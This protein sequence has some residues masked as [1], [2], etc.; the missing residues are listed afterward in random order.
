MIC[1]FSS[2]IRAWIAA[3]VSAPGSAGT[4]AAADRIKDKHPACLGVCAEPVQCPTLFNGGAG[5]HRIEGIGDKMAPLILNV[6]S[7]DRVALVDDATC[8]DVLYDLVMV[9]KYRYEFGISG[10]CNVLAAIQTA[11]AEGFNKHQ[12]VVTVAT[13]GLDRY[14]TYIKEYKDPE[15]DPL[16]RLRGR[17]ARILPDSS[18]YKDTSGAAEQERLHNLKDSLWARWYPK[19]MLAAMRDPAWWIREAARVS[20]IDETGYP[21]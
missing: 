18:N 4:F 7:V 3:F 13:D 8:V 14:Q 11:R 2:E 9:L 12:A 16:A 15:G 21:E 19:S 20:E 5:H 6:L 17:L 10:V 1:F